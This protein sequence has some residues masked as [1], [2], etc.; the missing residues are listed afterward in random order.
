[1]KRYSQVG[2]PDSSVGK[3]FM[4]T[5]A[6]PTL[7]PHLALRKQSEAPRSHGVL[8][9]G[10]TPDLQVAGQSLPATHLQTSPGWMGP[11][12]A[13][14]V[15]EGRAPSRLTTLCLWKYRGAL[16]FCL[17]GPLWS[18]LW[19]A[20]VLHVSTKCPWRGTKINFPYLEV[21]LTVNWVMAKFHCSPRNP[22][23]P[24]APKFPTKFFRGRGSQ[25]SPSDPS[26]ARMGAWERVV[27]DHCS[28]WCLTSMNQ[29]FSTHAE[30]PA[31]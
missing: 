29:G 19:K 2:W 23:H 12:S 6:L 11:R 21:G 14:S 8:G 9:Q 3:R 27:H 18:E 22:N 31:H 20:S 26:L 25:L 30:T 24:W 15:S 7:C 16:Y 10:L 17:Q 4:K 1:M 28:L 5:S 13:P